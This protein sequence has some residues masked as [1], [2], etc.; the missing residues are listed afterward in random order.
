MGTNIGA[1]ENPR[2]LSDNTRILRPGMKSSRVF[3]SAVVIDYISNPDSELA[4][5]SP[6]S[7]DSGADYR[8]SLK[9]GVYSVGNPHLV[10]RMPRNSI[11]AR[12][13]SDRASRISAPEI[14]Y[15]FFSPH[16]CMPVKA[17]EQVWVIFEQAG[18]KRTVGYWVCRRPSDL[19]VDDI[20]YTH[21]D[22]TSLDLYESGEDQSAEASQE[23]SDV[24]P[25]SFNLGGKD[26]RRFNTLPGEYPY[27]DIVDNSQSYQTEFLGE[28]VPRFSKRSTDLSLQGSH[29]TLVSL[30]RDRVGADQ[31]AEGEEDPDQKELSGT[32]DIVAGRG[33]KW[34]AGEAAA[35]VNTPTA[36]TE[37]NGEAG[38]P[39]TVNGDANPKNRGYEEIDK[40]PAISGNASNVN[41]GDPD[42]ENDLAR[43]YISM[44]TD[45]DVNFGISA[46][47]ATS[48]NIDVADRTGEPFVIMKSTNTRI[49]SRGD[50]SIK[51]VKMADPDTENSKEASIVIDK[52]G[53]IQIRTDSRIEL[54][55]KGASDGT[56]DQPYLRWDEFQSY[57]NDTLDRLKDD[58]DAL[59]TDLGNVQIALAETK[60]PG[61][62]S[63]DPA[64][65][66]ASEVGLTYTG[67]HSQGQKD[68]TMDPIK[69]DVIFGE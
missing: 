30:G 26:N 12:I 17:G 55:G 61:Y 19:Q 20:N 33:L 66:I 34:D 35:V 45:G 40:A 2:G 69:S 28:P 59:N 31:Y 52:S 39:A 25:F 10:D 14:F 4:V 16:L 32:I 51:I 7:N 21:E 41:E 43:T 56:A 49:I 64:V 38:G 11:V 9:T 57:M 42:F 58:M 8:T 29:N 3:Y 18:S 53:N 67:D 37:P 50:G 46:L 54:A 65:K 15:P 27:K 68:D 63:P 6:D 5:I 62:G 60:T 22:R 23:G 13:V 1:F 44:K 47:T 48:D 36:A 24:D